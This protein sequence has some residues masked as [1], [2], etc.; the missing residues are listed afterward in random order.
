MPRS[1]MASVFPSNNF[2][3]VSAFYP[4]PLEVS[5]IAFQATAGQFQPSSA[6]IFTL[7]FTLGCRALL[8][9]LYLFTL[10]ALRCQSALRNLI[11]YLGVSILLEIKKSLWLALFYIFKSISFYLFYFASAYFAYTRT[12]YIK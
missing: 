9:G 5:L 3:I 7:V 1:S 8:E 11:D 10:Y 6:Y 2:V 4:I 12:I